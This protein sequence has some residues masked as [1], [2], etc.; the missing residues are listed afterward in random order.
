MQEKKELLFNYLKIN[1]APILTNFISSNDI[2][3][4]IIL[5]SNISIN[6]LNGHYEETNFLPPKWFNQLLNSSSNK[7]LIIDKID[8]ISKE[9]Q[10]K[11]KEILK[12]RKISTFELPKDCRII[13]T[14]NK[15]NNEII[16]DEILSLAV[17]I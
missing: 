13:I 4:A 14:V 15:I 9:E 17:I 2:E 3:N 5:P 6:E 1:I 7:I 8:S 11:F 10:L 16:N 12:Y